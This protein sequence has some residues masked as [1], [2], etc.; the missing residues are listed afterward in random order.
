MHFYQPQ[1][2][3]QAA[4]KASE[5]KDQAA[6][7]AQQ[8]KDSAAKVGLV[9][10]PVLAVTGSPDILCEADEHKLTVPMLTAA[11]HRIS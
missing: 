7:S 1:A 6:A 5:I 9:G 8:A 4:A 11:S 3:R 10:S 2:G